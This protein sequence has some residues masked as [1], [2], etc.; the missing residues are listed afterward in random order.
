[1][2]KKRRK[3][4]LDFDEDDLDASFTPAQAEAFFAD[5]ATVTMDPA[6]MAPA[7]LPSETPTLCPAAFDANREQVDHLVKELAEMW[8]H[9]R[10][11]RVEMGRKFIELKSLVPHGKY[12]ETIEQRCGIPYNTARDY[13][14]EALAADL[15]QNY[16]IRSFDHQDEET[17]QG[18]LEE[19]A[20]FGLPVLNAHA[21]RVEKAKEAARKRRE[22]LPPSLNARVIF[23]SATVNMRDEIKAGT[24]DL[25]GERAAAVYHEHCSHMLS[26]SGRCFRMRHIALNR[27]AFTH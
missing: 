24:K 13:M 15:Q 9:V 27:S 17:D 26:C 2:E 20:G 5:M 25:G 3:L 4:M 19:N 1:M 6:G 14:K 8:L 23:R 21:E 12:Q 22:G 16:G 18:S 11:R 10:E 7:L